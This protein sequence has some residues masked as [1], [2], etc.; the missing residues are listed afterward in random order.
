MGG[1]Y[2]QDHVEDVIESYVRSVVPSLV[3][4]SDICPKDL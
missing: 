3:E 2:Y 4:R 1:S